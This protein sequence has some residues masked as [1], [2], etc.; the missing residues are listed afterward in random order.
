MKTTDNLDSTIRRHLVTRGR[1]AFEDASPLSSTDLVQVQQDALE[2]VEKYLDF[3]KQFENPGLRRAIERNR[4]TILTGVQD[5]ITESTRRVTREGETQRRTRGMDVAKAALGQRPSFLVIDNEICLEGSL[6]QSSGW[7][8]V[9][10]RPEV[11]QALRLRL[12][13]V[14]LISDSSSS[15]VGTGF[16]ISP[17]LLITNRHVAE[18]IFNLAYPGDPG[19]LKS[20]DRLCVVDFSRDPSITSTSQKVVLA[21]VKE[22]RFVAPQKIVEPLPDAPGLF[23]QVDVAVLEV[24]PSP[25]E[26]LPFMP[27]DSTVPELNQE[28][29]ILVV[30]HPFNDERYR[31]VFEEQA[32]T[33]LAFDAVFGGKFQYKHA[34]PGYAKTYLVGGLAK[35]LRESGAFQPLKGFVHDASTLEGNSGSPVV[36]MFG[37]NSGLGIHFWGQAASQDG[38]VANLAHVLGEVLDAPNH[39]GLLAHGRTL[40]EVISRSMEQHESNRAGS[41]KSRGRVRRR[42]QAVTS[43]CGN[44]KSRSPEKSSRKRGQHDVEGS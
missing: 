9:L 20:P 37:N 32:G 12:A 18:K 21:I 25:G 39:P 2:R 30:G 28:I 13:S 35:G 14:G 29:E 41:G 22:L 38:Q 15:P 40:Q 34:A 6:A 33:A 23:S 8:Q 3:L 44:I 24:Q 27:L 36:R 1:R 19:R 42:E 5:G 43:G 26:D 17:S 31:P 11:R 4:L 16:C 7:E 10:G